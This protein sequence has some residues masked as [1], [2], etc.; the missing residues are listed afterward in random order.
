MLSPDSPERAE[1]DIDP[2]RNLCF[3]CCSSGRSQGAGICVSLHG[4][5][6]RGAYLCPIN[7]LQVTSGMVIK[8]LRFFPRK[9]GRKERNGKEGERSGSRGWLWRKKKKTDKVFLTRK[10][11]VTEKKGKGRWRHNTQHCPQA[12]STLHLLS[13]L[14]SPPLPLPYC[15]I[16]QDNKDISTCC[17]GA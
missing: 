16:F 11:G 9:R 8:M 15:P 3:E 5:T 10:E 1:I 4:A 2:N 7:T 17:Q 13:E 14:L 6:C 12:F